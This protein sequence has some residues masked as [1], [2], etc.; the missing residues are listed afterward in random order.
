[1]LALINASPLNPKNASI[2]VLPFKRVPN[3]ASG[4]PA[5][6]S[7]QLAAQFRTLTQVAA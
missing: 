1:M 2:I 3:R 5:V 4:R 6:T 7:K